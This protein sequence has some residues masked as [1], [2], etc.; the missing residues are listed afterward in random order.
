MFNEQDGKIAINDEKFVAPD[1]VNIDHEIL[2]HLEFDGSFNRLGVGER[3][4]IYNLENNYSEGHAYRLNFRCTNNMVEYEALILGLKL[5]RNLEAKRVY[6]MGDSELVTKQIN[7]VY[8]TKDP[9]LSCYRGTI[10][11][12]LN[13]FLETKLAV[14]PR[15]HNMQAHSLAMFSSTCKL[16]FQPNHQY[17]AEVRHRLAIPD[18]LKN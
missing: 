9:R 10:V 4:W 5:V 12:I 6:V 8:M 2:W 15:K 1:S 3:V 14:I 7:V 11:E 17:I 13:T 16:P 18:N